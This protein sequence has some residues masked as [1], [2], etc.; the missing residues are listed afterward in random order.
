MNEKK[1]V[2]SVKVDPIFK[3]LL[4]VLAEY[5][6]DAQGEV[7]S[8]A[9]K[10]Y[11]IDSTDYIQSINKTCEENGCNLNGIIHDSV[12]SE[13]ELLFKDNLKLIQKFNDRYN[14]VGDEKFED[15]PLEKITTEMIGNSDYYSEWVSFIEQEIRNAALNRVDAETNEILKISGNLLFALFPNLEKVLTVEVKVQ[16]CLFDMYTPITWAYYVE[17][18]CE[19]FKEPNSTFVSFHHSQL[20]SFM[21]KLTHDEEALLYTII[22]SLESEFSNKIPSIG[23]ATG[24]LEEIF[25][26]KTFAIF[27]LAEV[28]SIIRKAIETPRFKI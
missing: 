8:N 17:L 20:S 6:K 26:Q 19:I 12:K 23:Q 22:H 1:V 21:K 2:L 18:I 5:L 24:F 3:E 15:T 14:I 28:D 25:K 16:A 10:K 4:S 9:L 27:N 11:A 13:G 7:F